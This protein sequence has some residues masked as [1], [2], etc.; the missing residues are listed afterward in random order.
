MKQAPGAEPRS[1]FEDQ[2]VEMDDFACSPWLEVRVLRAVPNSC[3]E[4]WQSTN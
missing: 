3:C 4:G 2:K 1:V